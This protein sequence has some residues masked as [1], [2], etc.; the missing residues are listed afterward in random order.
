MKTIA[1]IRRSTAKQALS[2]ERQKDQ[3]ME[4]AA[5]NNIEITDWKIEEPISG[6]CPKGQVEADKHQGFSYPPCNP[7]KNC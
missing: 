1:Y 6:K 2:V 4:Y 7:D 3:L 5:S